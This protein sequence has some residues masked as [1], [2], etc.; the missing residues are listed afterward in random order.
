MYVIKH[1]YT[2]RKDTLQ[3]MP[4]FGVRPTGENM[5][6]FGIWFQLG[7]DSQLGYVV[8]ACNTHTYV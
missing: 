7:G 4:L 8:H 3:R 6:D 1:N 2:Y 5:R